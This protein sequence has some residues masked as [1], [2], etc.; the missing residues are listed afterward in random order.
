M[1][2]MAGRFEWD[3][4]LQMVMAWCFGA[5]CFSVTC[6]AFLLILPFAFPGEHLAKLPNLQELDIWPCYIHVR[7]PALRELGGEARLSARYPWVATRESY[8]RPRHGL[9]LKGGEKP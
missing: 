2:Q 4:C 9:C 7:T 1:V 6:Y 8:A 5:A 3:V